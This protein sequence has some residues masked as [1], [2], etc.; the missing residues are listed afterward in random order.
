[1]GFLEVQILG[2]AEKVEAVS[3]DGSE[4]RLL[5]RVALC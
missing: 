4:D 3:G 5:A 2:R 1:M